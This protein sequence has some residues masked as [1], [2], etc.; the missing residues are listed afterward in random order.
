MDTQIT[1]PT[2][3]PRFPM[4][5]TLDRRWV[6]LTIAAVTIAAALSLNWS[7]L[8]AIGVAPLI[9]SALPCVAMCGLG[10]CMKSSGGS[11]KGGVDAGSAGGVVKKQ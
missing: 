1:S 8:V 5:Y 3:K 9:L 10:L 6:L 11:C 4:R 2:V 7:L